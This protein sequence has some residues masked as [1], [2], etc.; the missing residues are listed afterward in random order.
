[1]S[2][3]NPN[4][5]SVKGIVRP[6]ETTS[7]SSLSKRSGGKGANQAVAVAKAGGA[8]SLVGAIGP[9]GDAVKEN[10]AQ[11]GVDVQG[12]ERVQV[13]CWLFA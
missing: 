13:S 4:F 5:S 6:G 2:S 10:V 12:I 1:M 7:S 3:T 9:D 11:F 8:V